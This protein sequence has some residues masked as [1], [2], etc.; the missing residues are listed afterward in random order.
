M[1]D[2]RACLRERYLEARDRARRV[3][4]P[5]GTNIPFVPRDVYEL[6]W[7]KPD[8]TYAGYGPLRAGAWGA[9]DPHDKLVDQSLSFLEAGLPKGQAY[10]FDIRRNKYGQ[11]TADENFRDVSNPDTLRHYLWRHYVDAG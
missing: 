6:D 7:A 2:Y 1:S 4:L 3:P 8:W 9:L 5:D 11:P 10:Y